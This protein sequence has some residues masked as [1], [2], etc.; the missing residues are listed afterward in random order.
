[1][2]WIVSYTVNSILLEYY[3]MNCDY[4]RTSFSHMGI[5]LAFS[6]VANT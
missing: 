6:F 2:V 3:N 4:M 1:M 5:L